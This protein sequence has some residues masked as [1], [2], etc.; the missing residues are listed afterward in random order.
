MSSDIT[1]DSCKFYRNSAKIQS[2]LI[3]SKN[4]LKG[5]IRI[6]NSQ[7][8]N[9]V[10]YMNLVSLS[11]SKMIVKNT[12]FINNIGAHLTNGF[13]MINSYLECEGILVDNSNIEPLLAEK[14]NRKLKDDNIEFGFFSINA[15]S[16]VII[17]KSEFKKT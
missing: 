14:L 11:D 8:E 4:N 5:V 1:L 6:L 3:T 7:I 15:R 13:D 12:K 10:S 9:H 2:S 16:N 17:T